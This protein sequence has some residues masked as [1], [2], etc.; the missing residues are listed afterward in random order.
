MVTRFVSMGI[1]T[2]HS[3]T[4]DRKI[5]FCI[6]RIGKHAIQFLCKTIR[7][8]CQ[9]NKALYVLWNIPKILPSVTFSNM[10][11]IL[12][13]IESINKIPFL[14]TG[15]HK[16]GF[17]IIQITVV[18][19][20]L[21][22]CLGNLLFTHLFG[23][24]RNTVII[25]SIFEGFGN[26]LT[27]FLVGYISVRLIKADTSVIVHI[28]RCN[29]GIQRMLCIKIA[30]SFHIRIHNY[31]HRMVTDH[32]VC[33]ACKEVPHRQT[34]VLVVKG[35]KRFHHIIHPLGLRKCKQRMS[36]TIG[37]PQR[38]G[39]I[40]HPAVGLMYLF[41]RA[42]I[43]AIHI[44]VNSR[45]QHAMVQSCIEI[46]EIVNITSFNFN[47]TKLPVPAICRFP[48]ITIE[49]LVGSFG[50]QIL[51]CAFHAYTRYCRTYQY[52]IVLLCCKIK[53]THIGS[54]HP[55]LI[56]RINNRCSIEFVSF[57]RFRKFGNKIN[58]L[59]T[60][61]TLRITIAAD[62]HRIDHLYLRVGCKIPVH[63]FGQIQINRS[64]GLWKRI[65]LNSATFCGSQF[66]IN[67][68]IFQQNPVI[69]RRS[70]F[71]VMRK[72]GVNSQRS[73]SLFNRVR[74]RHKGNII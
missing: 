34:S 68:I 6:R 48:V 69:S 55:F 5:I 33:F 42:I 66:Y 3:G 74:Y 13:G 39:R 15:L 31:R 10:R 16:S 25:E 46:G 18:L 56:G 29:T 9:T 40:I 50:K 61:P 17:R 51:F 57:K 22:E 45:S 14:I 60:C 4:E 28:G 70:S 67:I 44:A 41:I 73:R 43:T 8:S 47:L 20:A 19:R 54:S 35:K 24:Q 12:L 2:N 71:V 23:H 62:G 58:A 30:D 63:G 49:I 26:R 21:A 59:S 32:H 72:Q 38:E 36:R 7:T 11:C 52:L 65:L 53:S 1:L 27:L 64:I 37:I